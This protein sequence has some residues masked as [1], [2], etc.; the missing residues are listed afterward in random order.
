MKEVGAVL[1][2]L[3]FLPHALPACLQ[4]NGQPCASCAGACSACGMGTYG[5]GLASCQKC[6]S[7]TFSATTQSASVDKCVTCGI[8]TTTFPTDT[9]LTTCAT[10]AT[11][12]KPLPR[13]SQDTA[14]PVLFCLWTCNAGYIRQI[15][16]DPPN[17]TL[18]YVYGSAGYGSIDTAAMLQLYH[19]DSDYCCSGSLATTGKKLLGCSKTNDGVATACPAISNAYYYDDGTSAKLDRCNDWACNFGYYRLGTFCAPQPNCLSTTTYNRDPTTGAYVVSANGSFACVACS[20][21]PPGS[22]TITPCNKTHDTVCRLCN[23]TSYSVAGGRC[24]AVPLGY[25]PVVV[26]YSQM[27]AVQGRPNTYSDGTTMTWSNYLRT[28]TRCLTN[29]YGTRYTPWRTDPCTKSSADAS[30]CANGTC[31]TECNPWNGTGGFYSSPYDASVCLPCQFN[32]ALCLN[33]Q[34]LSMATCGP[35]SFPQCV[36][37]PTLQVDNVESWVNPRVLPFVSPYPCDMVCK[38]GYTKTNNAC[39]NCPLIPANAKPMDGSTNCSWVCMK[40]YILSAG[41]CAA[42]PTPPSCPIGTYLGYA[43]ST[44]QCKTCCPCTSPASNIVF[45]TVG[46]YGPNTCG[47]ACKPGHFATGF[48]SYNNPMECVQCTVVDCTAGLTYLSPCAAD[49]NAACMMCDECYPGYETTVPC[50]VHNNTVCEPCKAT[51]LPAHAEW[52]LQCAWDCAA[53][54]VL[55]NGTAC[56]ACKHASDCKPSERLVSTDGCGDCVACDP[57][58]PGRA[59]LGDGRCGTYALTCTTRTYPRSSKAS[60]TTD[61]VLCPWTCNAGYMQ[62]GA[63]ESVGLGPF[64]ATR[65]LSAA[66]PA[67]VTL[68]HRESDACCRLAGV[69]Q[70]LVGCTQ[71]ADGTMQTCPSKANARYVLVGNKTARC[72]DYECNAGYVATAQASCVRG[73]TATTT[74]PTPTTTTTTPP[75][76]TTRR[77]TTPPPPTS[78]PPAQDVFASLVQVQLPAT[79]TK[80]TNSVLAQITSSIATQSSCASPCR[81]VV[82]SITNAS[83]ATIACV[84]GTCPGYNTVAGRRRVLAL[85]AIRIT[86][87]IITPDPLPDTIV[88]APQLGG[89]PLVCTVN[90]NSAVDTNTLQQLLQAP[91]TLIVYIQEHPRIIVAPPSSSG[92]GAGVAV[93]LVLAAAAGAGAFLFLRKRGKE[94]IKSAMDTRTIPV[95]ITLRSRYARR[96]L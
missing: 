65:G 11:A 59:Y 46:D 16:A 85:Q 51:L 18:T 76:T 80:L 1:L 70:Q 9:G 61:V 66:E 86:F 83:G 58:P 27:P 7:G 26:Q 72:G 20:K 40:G 39:T 67:T 81:T 36:D 84:N 82:L 95:R 14:G 54:Y 68:F 6:P 55:T 48:D 17:S 91:G 47:Y 45:T 30:R 94:G 93:G 23:S 69:G 21:C 19:R 8:G 29:P 37:C 88:I 35:T 64:A 32:A 74:T 24:G 56:A 89:S 4:Y 78:P 90:L 43:Q 79:L 2:T 52:G 15:P 44:D 96:T 75:P 50:S 10:C 77:A 92:V 5:D 53:G 38:T 28:Y 60:S 71:T 73:T 49:A 57:L 22:E 62:V 87:G 13:S 63:N 12:N 25:M 42:C 33:S 31:P 41:A 3:A 34:Y